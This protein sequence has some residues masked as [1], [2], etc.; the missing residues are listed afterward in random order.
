MKVKQLIKKLQKCNP[1]IEVEVDEGY[2]CAEVSSVSLG[3]SDGNTDVIILN[4]LNNEVYDN[5]KNV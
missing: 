3:K 1:D 2:M 5:V 4:Y